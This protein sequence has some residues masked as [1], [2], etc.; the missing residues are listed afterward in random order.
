ME[1]SAS[2]F[3]CFCLLLQKANPTCSFRV[4][5]DANHSQV[6]RTDAHAGTLLS[7]MGLHGGRLLDGVD[8]HNGHSV[9]RDHAVTQIP[10]GGGTA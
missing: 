7:A 2:H 4:H 5:L 1:S 3:F 10:G 8:T 9:A 6:G